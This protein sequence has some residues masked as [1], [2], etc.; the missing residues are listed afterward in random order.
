MRLALLPAFALTAFVKE[1]LQAVQND[2]PQELLASSVS[3]ARRA[4]T[5]T[6]QRWQRQYGTAGTV[7][8]YLAESRIWFR[9]SQSH[10]IGRALHC[11]TGSRAP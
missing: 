11:V 10:S 9:V 7:H 1:Q 8:T 3:A 6:R 2:L 4:L 5:L